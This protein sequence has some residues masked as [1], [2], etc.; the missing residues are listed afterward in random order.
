MFHLPLCWN[1]DAS[2]PQTPDVRSENG[3]SP[4]FTWLASP[5]TDV[6]SSNSSPRAG[7]GRFPRRNR[8]ESEVS[9][10]GSRKFTYLREYCA[11]IRVTTLSVC[12]RICSLER[13]N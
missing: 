5:L 8:R 10:T 9:E 2:V 4:V 11:I 3:Y 12:S 13:Q 7:V 1:A 6:E